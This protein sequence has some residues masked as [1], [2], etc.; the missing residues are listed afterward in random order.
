MTISKK[1]S[2]AIVLALGV[3][4]SAGA[5]FADEHTL[6]NEKSQILSFAQDLRTQ[7]STQAQ[8]VAQWLDEQV[9][10]GS[11]CHR[12]IIDV[13]TNYNLTEKSKLTLLSEM[14]AQQK[15]ENRKRATHRF[16]NDVC[17]GIICTGSGAL[18]VWAVI[19]EMKNPRPR[20]YHVKPGVKVTYLSNSG[21]RV[22]TTSSTWPYTTTTYRY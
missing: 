6:K 4:L 22:Q 5:F 13:I 2:I 10:S 17:A 1:L 18:F 15:S 21:V 7:N 8:K 16:V 11:E 14:I 3:Q 9:I 20:Y 19:E 12:A